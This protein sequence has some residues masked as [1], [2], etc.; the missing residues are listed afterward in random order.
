MDR[1]LARSFAFAECTAAAATSPFVISFAML[2]GL[3]RV[4]GLH[5]ETCG[6]HGQARI[7][8]VWMG[9]SFHVVEAVCCPHAVQRQFDTLFCKKGGAALGSHDSSQCITRSASIAGRLAAGINW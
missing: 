7:T 1:S 4:P 5:V 9:V 2:T 8:M 3:P 6:Q